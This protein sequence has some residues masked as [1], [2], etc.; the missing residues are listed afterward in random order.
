MDI[1]LLF[2]YT[3]YASYIG[4]FSQQNRKNTVGT[5]DKPIWV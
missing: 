2:H 4:P 3:S 1:N 5:L